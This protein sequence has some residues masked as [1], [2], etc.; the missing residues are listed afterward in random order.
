GSNVNLGC[1]VVFVNYDGK[2][3]NRSTV[4]DN[5]FVGCNVNL[6]APVT[7]KKDSYIAAGTT[8]TK[9]VPEG[10]LSIGRARQE[11]KEDW[12]KKFK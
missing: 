4:E 7:V 9:D 10:S 3:K 12:M 1:G 11:N 5:C 2:K 8:I 6:V